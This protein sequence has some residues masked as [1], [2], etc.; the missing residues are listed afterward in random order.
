MASKI[1][2]IKFT[3]FHSMDLHVA[4]TIILSISDQQTWAQAQSYL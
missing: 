4:L 1:K 2:A 3:I